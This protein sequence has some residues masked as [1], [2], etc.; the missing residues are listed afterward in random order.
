MWSRNVRSTLSRAGA[1]L[2]LGAGLALVSAGC[3][4]E[5]ERMVELAPQPV[6]EATL[7]VTPTSLALRAERLEPLQSGA[8]Y[9]VWAQTED[10]AQRLGTLLAD[11]ALEAAWDDLDFSWSEVQAVLVYREAEA[12]PAA[13]SEALRFRF[14]TNGLTGSWS[15]EFAPLPQVQ[16]SAMRGMARMSGSMMDVSVEGLPEAPAGMGWAVWV[17]WP[18]EEGDDGVVP[19]ACA[20]DAE[21][22]GSAAGGHDEAPAA[23][24]GG[25]GAE[26]EFG[27]WGMAHA[28]GD[29]DGEGFRGRG[30]GR[31]GAEARE[32]LVTLEDELGVEDVSPLVVLRGAVRVPRIERRA[33]GG[34]H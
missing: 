21:A 29:L 11:G 7:L 8:S 22:E 10:G 33:A 2:T 6:P 31:M 28:M 17:L 19:A 5:V 18:A 23:D 24:G 13:P 26:G 15:S 14:E 32:V 12:S 30:M 25:E 1:W 20:G 34:G 9:T 27:C 16:V 4:G 3:M